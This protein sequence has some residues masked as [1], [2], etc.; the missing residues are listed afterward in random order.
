MSKKKIKNDIAL[1]II[2]LIVGFLT[3]FIIKS[4]REYGAIV[5]ITVDGELVAEYSL[6]DKGEYVLNGGTNILVISEGEAF[7]REA[8]CPDGLC[9]N[10]GKISLSGERIVCLPNRVMV[11]VIG[12]GDDIFAN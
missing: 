2:L 7:V 11:E 4:Q 8:S 5:R 6:F 12:E 3:F 1:V 9:V 10:Q